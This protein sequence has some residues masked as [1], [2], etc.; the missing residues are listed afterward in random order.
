MMVESGKICGGG[1]A[2]WTERQ[3]IYVWVEEV[4]EVEY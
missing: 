2:R 4:K 3:V 1:A